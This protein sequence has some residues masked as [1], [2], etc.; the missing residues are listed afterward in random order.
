MGRDDE[1]GS[2]FSGQQ[3]LN[4]SQEIFGLLKKLLTLAGHEKRRST[5]VRNEH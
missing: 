1:D 4:G 5:P 2:R 3:V